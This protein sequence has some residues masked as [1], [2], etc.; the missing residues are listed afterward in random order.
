MEY[1]LFLGDDDISC[2]QENVVFFMGNP[3]ILDEKEKHYSSA[4]SE[5][6][7]RL[8]DLHLYHKIH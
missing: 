4:L 7:K 6:L 3:Y 8:E 2:W 1:T 5:G